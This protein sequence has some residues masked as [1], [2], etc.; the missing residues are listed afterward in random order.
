VM[1]MKRTKMFSKFLWAKLVSN[2]TTATKRDSV[3]SN[4]N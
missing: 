2:D 3:K 1:P 4:P